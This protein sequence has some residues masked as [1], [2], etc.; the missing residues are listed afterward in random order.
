MGA[1]VILV[2]VVLGYVA[3]RELNRADPAS[4]VDEVDYTRTVE[5][6]RGQAGFDLLAPARLPEGWRAT[7]VDFVPGEEGRWHLGMLTDEGQYVG[8]EQSTASAESMVQTHVDP[9]AARGGPVTV[10]GERWRTWTDDSGD[11]ALV[12]S[13]G[14]TTTLVV[15]HDVPQAELRAFAAALR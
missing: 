11:L 4:P 2:A 12:R 8:L 10:E 7:S 14:D 1:M 9:E 6:A 15:G 3:F 5:F 13:T